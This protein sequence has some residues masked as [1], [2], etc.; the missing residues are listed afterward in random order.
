MKKAGTLVFALLLA[1]PS[2]AV[3]GEREQ[4]IASDQQRMRGELRS[5]PQRGYTVHEIDTP[6]GRMVKEY[7]AAGGMVFGVSWRGPA[8][9][10]LQRLLGSY[11]TEFQ[12]SAASAPGAHR[13]ALAV[14]TDRLVVESAGHMRDLHGRAYVPSL[15][16]DGITEEVVQ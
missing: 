8:L 15:I 12:Q 1:V 6:D 11:F 2:S 3:L 4:S 5:T 7:V 14:R 9:P 16:P 13:R 10:D